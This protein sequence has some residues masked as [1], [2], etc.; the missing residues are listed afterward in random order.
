MILSKHLKLAG[1]RVYLRN[2][3]LSDVSPKYQAWLADPE[4][5]RYLI[6]GPLT[7]S[8]SSLQAYVQTQLQSPETLF[9][10]I[11]L[12]EGDRHIGNIKLSPIDQRH[13]RA[14]LGLLIGEK[15]TWGKGYATEAIQLLT[16]YAFQNLE[17]HKINASIF[18]PNEGSLKAFQKAGY[19]VGA[20]MKEHFRVGTQFLDEYI[21]EK[22][23]E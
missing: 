12:K 2:M 22:F 14:T 4:V 10:A 15:D 18:S 3:D 6:S 16:H 21:V 13:G 23:V 1:D 8:L 9:L 19:K 7:C 11:V 5:A 17:L 20:I